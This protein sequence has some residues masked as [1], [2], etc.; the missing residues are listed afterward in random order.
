MSI[1]SGE[2]AWADALLKAGG[3]PLTA[4]N[5][6]NVVGWENAES[7]TTDQASGGGEGTY[8]PLNTMEPQGASSFTPG[9]F[10]N[11]P[12]LQAGVDGTE[13]A[14]N[15]GL[16]PQVQADLAAGNVPAA[17]FVSDL[18]ATP[19]NAQH[20]YS[21]SE[22]Q[23][24]TGLPNAELTSWWDPGKIIQKAAGAASG[25][26]GKATGAAAGS[27]WSTIAPNLKTAAIYALALGTG[28]FLI[29]VGVAVEGAEG[30]KKAAPA[31]QEA[32]GDAGDVAGTAAVVA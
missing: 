21:V 18:N 25:A 7:G 5:V 11:Y 24:A 9:G 14:L 27:I 2:L 6:A 1:L 30:V 10:A 15:N 23:V 31:V 22:W 16:Y 20:D 12:S 29:V 32:I 19:W 8:N 4:D 26:V 28:A 13:A 17:Q 3:D